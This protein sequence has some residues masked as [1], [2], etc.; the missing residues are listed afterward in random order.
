M[1]ELE[2]ELSIFLWGPKASGKTFLVKALLHELMEMEKG[3]KLRRSLDFVMTI[4][5]EE[6]RPLR[7]GEDVQIDLTEESSFSQYEFVTRPNRA[8]FSAQASASFHYLS[9]LD[10]PG[11][12][13]TLNEENEEMIFVDEMIKGSDYFIVLIDPENIN[14]ESYP[15]Y[16]R[17]F[18]DQIKGDRKRTLA[19]CISKIDALGDGMANLKNFKAILQRG[20]I[21]VCADEVI[22]IINGLNA[23]GHKMKFFSVSSAGKV[24]QGRRRVPNIVGNEI[25]DIDNWEPINVEKPFFWLLE[26][27]ENDWIEKQ[28]DFNGLFYR[29]WMFG[30]I[31]KEARK[32]EKYSYQEI[33]KKISEPI[34][35][36]DLVEDAPSL[37]ENE[38]PVVEEHA[39]IRIS[40]D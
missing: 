21:K 2:K 11:E 27:I 36:S 12:A 18:R 37:I 26:N 31:F 35:P 6:L 28:K 15:D 25:Q 10:S 16:L 40:S 29:S 14:V 1:S 13:I 19:I 8:T 38:E 3:T 30:K 32:E 23:D 22:K 20:K 24:Q 39:S 17:V 33:S 7:A 9:L 4:G 34:K 5:D